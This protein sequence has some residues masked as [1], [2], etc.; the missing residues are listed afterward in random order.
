LYSGGTL[1]RVHVERVSADE[2]EAVVDEVF[3]PPQNAH[4]AEVG[5]RIGGFAANAQPCASDTTSGLSVGSEALVLYSAGVS[6]D[7]P[8]CS[9]F[10]DCSTRD[11]AKLAEPERPDCWNACADETSE[12][13]AQ[14]RSAA[15]LDGYFSWAIP[16]TDP[17]SFGAS[18]ELPRSEIPLLFS[19]ESCVERFPAPPAPPC[20]DTSVV[21]CSATPRPRVSGLGSLASPL[22]LLLTF[23]LARRVRTRGPAR[24]QRRNIF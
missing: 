17:L 21:R 15:L 8:N 6:R 2:L 12:F 19:H 18:H 5:D 13:C 20:N 14:Q 4:A 24:E 7:Y 3:A 23:V 16:W 10:Q 22:A 9:A 1:L 11:C